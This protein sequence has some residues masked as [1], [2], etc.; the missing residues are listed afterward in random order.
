M[1]V[2]RRIALAI[3]I[4]L[5]TAGSSL[6]APKQVVIIL[7]PGHG[8]KDQGGYDGRGFRFENKWVPEDAYTYDVAQRISSMATSNGWIVFFT[9]MDR[10]E[11]QIYGYNEN[12]II[13]AK[14]KLVYN[15]P[16]KNIVVYSGKYGLAKR[17]KVINKIDARYPNAIKIFISLHFDDANSLLSGAQIFTSHRGARHPF[18]KILAKKFDEAE[19]NLKFGFIPRFMINQYNELVVLKD[20]NISPRVLIELGNFKNERDRLLMLR[21]SGREMYARIIISAI[22]E[23][24]KKQT[25]RDEG[26]LF[27]LFE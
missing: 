13:P 9:V 24:T 5:F 22:E 19:M 17:I 12:E 1:S 23:Y 18:V 7:D 14:K 20:S 27:I 21:S 26:F 25:P 3:A 16:D 15:I 4:V 10:N 6:A 11:N 8:G 2:A